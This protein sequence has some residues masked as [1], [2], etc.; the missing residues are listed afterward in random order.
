MRSSFSFMVVCCALCTAIPATAAPL[1]I[2]GSD[3]FGDP[4][5]KA[6][7]ADGA[8]AGAE[9]TLE[10]Q[11]SLAGRQSLVAGRAD[12]ALLAQSPGAVDLVPIGCR[13]VPIAFA[14][15]VVIVPEENPLTQITFDQLGGVFGADEPLNLRRWGELGLVDEW[16]ARSISPVALGRRRCL[17]LDFFAQSVMGGRGLRANL[18]QV[19]E[20]KLVLDRLAV[21]RASVAVVPLAPASGR[22]VRALLVARGAGEVAFGPSSENI[23]SGDYPL[24][25][26]VLLVFRPERAA[27]LG[28]IV[29]F[30]SSDEAAA[31]IEASLLMPLPAGARAGLAAAIGG[32]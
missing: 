21:D 29:G 12:A 3:L 28:P 8:R 15:A 4:F 18:V 5:R 16:A 31:A 11:G 20:V 17:A 23:A 22:G 26:P 25:M 13:A 32:R 1:R 7:A 10:L 14:A 6:L 19:E 27:E 30:F 24:R 2:A 9:V